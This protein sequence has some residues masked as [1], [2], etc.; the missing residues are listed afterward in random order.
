MAMGRRKNRTRTPGLWI[1]ANELPRTGGHPFY[2][3]LNQVLDAHAFDEFVEAQCAPFYAETVGRPSLTPGTYFRLLLIGYFE[4]IDSERGIAWRTEDSLALRGFLGLGLDETP[5]EHSTISRTRRLID[6]ETHRTV[7]TWI[8]QVLATADLIRGKTIGIDA[9]TLEANAALRSIVR[10]DSGETCQE[11]LTRLAQASGIATPTRADLARLDRTR[12]KKGR[13]TDWRH[14][15]DPDARI[16]KMKDGR[17]HLAHKAEHAVD[18]ETGAIV[19]VTV[20]GA[21][22]AR[23]GVRYRHADAG[24]AGPIRSHAEEEGIQQ[25]LDAPRRSGRE[26]HEDEGR[27]DPFG[28]QSR[29]GG[30]PGDRG[31][32]R[33]HRA[34]RR[35]RRYDDHD[36][37]HHHG[38]RTGRSGVLAPFGVGDVTYPL[39]R[40]G[41]YA[42]EQ[43]AGT[44]SGRNLLHRNVLTSQHQQRTAQAPEFA[45]LAWVDWFNTRRLL[46]PIGYIPPAEYE[47]RYYEQVTVT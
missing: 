43:V 37:D 33:R 28:S 14:P 3:R 32:R 47:E 38:R 4:G 36:R 2:L 25:R 41:A 18:L 19:G 23:R 44:I 12:P 46:E 5:P 6:V 1:A 9:T 34:R 21:D 26:D 17:T 27:P 20:Q 30:G 39:A 45:T 15:H 35:R 16:T 22:P 31:H 11:F 40:K 7:F 42:T 24:R 29:A 10:R 13:N 8:L